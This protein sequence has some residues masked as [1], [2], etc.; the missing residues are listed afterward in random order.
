MSYADAQYTQY[1]TFCSPIKPHNRHWAKQIHSHTTEELLL[2]VS[3]GVCTIDSNGSTHQVPTPAFIWNRAGSYHLVSNAEAKDRN[4]YVVSFL[5]SF[6]S[7]IPKKL[8]FSDFMEGYG[9]FAL[10]LN[11]ERLKVLESYFKMLMGKTAPERQLLIPC[12][13]HNI[14][15]FL[16]SGAEPICSSDRHSYIFQ[17]L[18]LI[19]SSVG[20]K[21]T[22]KML[23]ERF[24]VSRNKLESDFKQATGQTMHTYRMHLQLQTA[25]LLLISTQQT[26]S[27]I[28]IACGFAD[29]C[30]M[31]RSFR[32]QYGITPKTFRE[33]LKQSPRW[34]R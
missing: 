16:K 21:F 13:F 18:A 25:R 23:A 6:L 10:P 20:Q 29:D 3:E 28:A 5:P 33:Q 15:L 30:H 9:M 26:Q 32:K 24:H 27:E 11:E 31:I 7:D 12:I 17:V 22:S 8:Q 4:S 34:S 1:S 19:E 14:T 2:I